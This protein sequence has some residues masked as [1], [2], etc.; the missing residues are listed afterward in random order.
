MANSFEI[1]IKSSTISLK[2][3]EGS[4]LLK[5]IKEF[6]L[7]G[8]GEN[9]HHTK[10][11]YFIYKQ[12]IEDSVINQNNKTL[13]LMEL[14]FLLNKPLQMFLNDDLLEKAEIDS[15]INLTF[16]DSSTKIFWGPEQYEFFKFFKNLYTSNKSLLN[17]R[18][19]HPSLKYTSKL[20]KY[21]NLSLLDKINEIYKHKIDTKEFK[22][23][24]E[25]FMFL[26]SI[27]F[28]KNFTADKVIFILGSSHLHNKVSFDEDENN[29]IDSVFIRV[30]N[31]I[32][33]PS[34]RIC[35]FP[36]SGKYSL[37]KRNSNNQVERVL[38]D[39]AKLPIWNVTR[40]KFRKALEELDGH[41]FI[42]DIKQLN[43]IGIDDEIFTEWISNSDF[44]ISQKNVTP[45]V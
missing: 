14:D 11:Y 41:T 20:C 19:I 33:S 1:E 7:I 37:F 18:F 4:F 10:E 36:I 24:R 22:E 26:E 28:V 31:Q 16:N 13:V 5:Q 30:K 23:L 3:L 21:Y 40:E 6:P 34:I 39:Y 35:L 43:S 15:F 8:I 25:E 2:K 12:I 38:A 27:Q 9:P 17:I 45:D 32:Q 44:I 29:A 42:T